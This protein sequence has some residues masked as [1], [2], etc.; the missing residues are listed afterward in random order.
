MNAASLSADFLVKKF[1]FT[2][3]NYRDVYPALESSIVGSQV[4]KTVIIT[5]ASQG[6][7][8]VRQLNSH[9]VSGGSANAKPTSRLSR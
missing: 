7:G 9:S 1:Q 8:K 6:I 2:N 5:G 4:G 3:K